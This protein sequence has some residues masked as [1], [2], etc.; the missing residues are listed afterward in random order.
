MEERWRLVPWWR[1]TAAE[2]LAAGE[3]LLEAAGAGTPA[4][5]WYGV[6][7]DALILGPRQRDASAVDEAACRAGGLGIYTRRSGGTAV[8]ADRFL[9]NL[10]VALPAGHRLAPGDVTLA[11]RWLG[12]ALAAG[13]TRLGVPATSLPPPAVRA[14]A[15]L[16]GGAFAIASVACFGGLSPYEVVAGGRKVVGLSQIRRRQGSLLQAGLPLRWD[17]ERLA[18]LLAGDPL[19]RATLAAELAQSAAGLHTWGLDLPHLPNLIAAL[20]AA[21][22]QA[23]GAR[24]EPRP[25]SDAERAAIAARAAADYA[26][27]IVPS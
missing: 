1:G 10:D 23:A 7:P 17:P 6:V 9:V 8:L 21:I 11:Y 27:L 12:E 14:E 4:L 18:G 25:W 26:P 5:H 20:T 3:L 2:V 24:L 13:L 22:E 19:W 16:R 15:A